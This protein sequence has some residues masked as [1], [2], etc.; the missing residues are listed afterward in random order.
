MLRALLLFAL[1]VAAAELP[2]A[3][4]LSAQWV[5][6]PRRQHDLNSCHAFAAVALIEAAH[7]RRTGRHVRLSEADLFVQRMVLRDRE[8]GF[9]LRDLRIGL[10]RGV[11]AG[12]WYELMRARYKAGVGKDELL[13]E[14]AGAPRVTVEGQAETMPHVPITCIG[15]Q[16]RRDHIMRLLAEGVPVGVGVLLERMREPFS[17]RGGPHYFVLT[18]YET[19]PSGVIFKARNTWEINPD[20]RESDLC[21]LFATTWL[22]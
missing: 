6:G 5:D 2:A 7:Y 12:D 21:A 15:R 13:P 17:S 18:G 22:R 16:R 14:A 20:V 9:L 11:A 8:S 3:V 19:T 10:E 4:D 1:P